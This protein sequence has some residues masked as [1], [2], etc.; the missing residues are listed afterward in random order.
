M[1]VYLA[2]YPRAGNSWVQ[3]LITR[4]FMY[5]TTDDSGP[6][7]IL[8]NWE[9]FWKLK[10]ITEAPDPALKHLVWNDY[11]AQF[12]QK[13]PTSADDIKN[14]FYPT[15]RFLLPGFKR[16]ITDSDRESLANE[17]EYFFV[18]TH[19]LPPGE[20]YEGEYVV[21]IIRHP[22]PSMW[23]YYKYLNN[24]YIKNS[25]NEII[26]PFSMEDVIGGNVDFGSWSDHLGKWSSCELFLKNRF[27]T[28][29]FQELVEDENQVCQRLSE[30][31]GIPF[32]QRQKV[33][34]KDKKNRSVGYTFSRGTDDGYEKF[35]S[36]KQLEQIWEKNKEVML[37]FNF[38]KPDFSKGKEDFQSLY[39]APWISR[40]FTQ[41]N[42]YKN[43]FN[44]S[45]EDL[46]AKKESHSNLSEICLKANCELVELR[47]IRYELKAI[48]QNYQ[49]EIIKLNK[50]V[51]T[52]SQ[53]ISQN[54]PEPL[55]NEIQAE[56]NTLNSLKN[57]F[58]SLL[59][60]Y[61]TTYL[62][63]LEKHSQDRMALAEKE[64]EIY[65]YKKQLEV[66]TANI[67]RM[68]SLENDNLNQVERLKSRN[69]ELGK[70]V[71]EYQQFSSKLVQDYN[72]LLE[73][74]DFPKV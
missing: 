38:E 55:V 72:K 31:L 33:T 61:N 17:K 60:E 49:N 24:L 18:K 41:A 57:A 68:Q 70:K 34:I 19:H 3:Q 64:A 71:S 14:G 21:H 74:I 47:N 44:K 45:N 62:K 50:Q 69:I 5:L 42:K 32:I 40:L 23:S 13:S 30:W 9:V 58:G 10:R 39:L 43:F 51:E 20:F 66:Y 28:V 63:F 56:T 8:P 7:D 2:S 29:R 36:I 12:Q 54:Q 52:L 53:G 16:K 65:R 26:K 22:G 4:H 27:L 67:N 73:E 48:L 25:I 15:H 37:S 46:N 11:T 1:I 35:F 6:R 59:N